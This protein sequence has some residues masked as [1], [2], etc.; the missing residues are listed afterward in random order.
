MKKTLHRSLVS[1]NER[2]FYNNTVINAA[3]LL[4]ALT[5]YVRRIK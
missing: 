3:Q 1:K 2:D 4:E 5:G